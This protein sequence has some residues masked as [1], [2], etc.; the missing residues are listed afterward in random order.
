MHELGDGVQTSVT[1]LHAKID[2]ATACLLRGIADRGGV[3]IEGD[4]RMTSPT[5][6]SQENH[7]KC[8]VFTVFWRGG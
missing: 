3:H 4:S 1:S 2:L 5:F 7:A 6:L 8:L